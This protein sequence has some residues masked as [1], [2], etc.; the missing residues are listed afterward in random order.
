VTVFTVDPVTTTFTEVTVASG[1]DRATSHR[2][3]MVEDFVDGEDND[4]FTVSVDDAAPVSGS[5]W[6]EY[7]R[8][9]EGN[10][11]RTVDSLLFRSSI[12]APV[13]SAVAGKGF[14]VDNVVLS[15]G[16]ATPTTAS[17]V[18]WNQ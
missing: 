4:T 15:T 5:S 2:L 3:S 10:P 18:L 9:S 6:E 17:T 14:L 16:P 1:L 13:P 8:D 12:A 11:S 7:F